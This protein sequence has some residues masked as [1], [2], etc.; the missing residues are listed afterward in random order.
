MIIKIGKTVFFS[1]SRSLVIAV[2]IF[3]SSFSDVAGQK[4]I[5]FS[6]KDGDAT[7]SDKPAL[8]ERLFFGGSF[9]LQL[10][11][12]TNIEISPVIGYWVLPRVAL[13]AGPSYRY[14]KYYSSRTSIYGGRTYI[15]YVV[16]RDLDKLI[17]LG[18]HTSLFLHAE[19]EML[20]LDSE[21]WRNVSLN[22]RR[23]T[24][25]TVLAGAGLSQQISKRGSINFIL[26][27]ALNQS[28]DQVYS[29]PE[30]RISFIF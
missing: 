27:W 12:V 24:V 15:Q 14:Y 1:L 7:D 3:I 18:I 9:A 17:P 8:S 28:E 20:S 25:N 16:F 30:I 22:P 5:T 26:L 21:Y 10:G 29:N 19:D 4:P 23:F 2:I 6:G 11:T 13:A